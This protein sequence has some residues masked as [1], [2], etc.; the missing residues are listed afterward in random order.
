MPDLNDIDDF[1]KRSVEHFEQTPFNESWENISGLLDK[2]DALLYKRK[3]K[4]SI[5]VIILLS[6]LVISISLYFYFGGNINY[7]KISG[8][9]RNLVN[10]NSRILSQTHD[11]KPN[12]LPYSNHLNSSNF[13]K[14]FYKKLFQENRIIPVKEFHSV[15][16]VKNNNLKRDGKLNSL[17]RSAIQD[18]DMSFEAKRSRFSFDPHIIELPKYEIEPTSLP[19]YLN[20]TLSLNENT[21]S[22]KNS[23]AIKNR[24]ADRYLTV[25]FYSTVKHTINNVIDNSPFNG[26]N[27][28]EEIGQIEKSRLAYS[29]GISGIYHFKKKWSFESGVYFLNSIIDVSHEVLHAFTLRNGSIGYQ[30]NSSSGFDYIKTKSDFPSTS[31][32]SIII[33]NGKEEL[34]YLRIPLLIDYTFQKNRWS[35]SPSIGFSFN[36]LTETNVRTELTHADRKE[37]I[38]I[39]KLKGGKKTYIGFVS[40]LN[41]GYQINSKWGVNIIPTYGFSITPV[42]KNS[43]VKTYTQNIGIGGGLNYRL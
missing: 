28:K 19:K 15:S 14:P 34:N 41:L 2:D 36:Y 9:G 35:L 18:P 4:R 5:D 38:T 33:K 23:V 16:F 29:F 30:F 20:S 43:L 32:D 25:G 24:K 40:N 39:N 12:D 42:T 7:S 3:Y 31:S 21:S 8:D 10:N 27:E 13:H 11:L 22:N 37:M 1:F 6:F 26:I 17:Q